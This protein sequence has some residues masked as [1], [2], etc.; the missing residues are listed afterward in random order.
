MNINE[1]RLSIEITMDEV[2]E[3]TDFWVRIPQEMLYAENENY[4]FW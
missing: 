1:E 3:K 4:V 2:P